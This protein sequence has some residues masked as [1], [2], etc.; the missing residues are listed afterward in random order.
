ME[1]NGRVA[2]G[3]EGPTLVG[4][5][6]VDDQTG[7]ELLCIKAGDGALYVNGERLELKEAKPLPSSD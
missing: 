4:K 1:G 5:R 3:H 6:Y 7:V 2:A